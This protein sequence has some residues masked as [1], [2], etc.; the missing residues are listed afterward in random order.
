MARILRK[1]F[2]HQP[3]EGDVERRDRISIAVLALVVFSTMTFS[4]YMVT[5]DRPSGWDFF[6]K[7]SIT[8]YARE[9]SVCQCDDVI[10]L[11]YL[12]YPIQYGDDQMRIAY[13]KSRD[14]GRTWSPAEILS[15]D[16]MR[17]SNWRQGVRIACQGNEVHLVWAEYDWITFGHGFW[18][19]SWILHR[20]SLDGGRSWEDLQILNDELPFDYYGFDVSLSE[21]LVL[22]AWI[23]DYAHGA[24][25]EVSYVV[26]QDHGYNWSEERVPFLQWGG[27]RP[28]M[29]V[30]GGTV[31]ALP[32]IIESSSDTVKVTGT[33]MISE[34][35]GESW[36]YVDIK[37]TLGLER[38][39]ID[40]LVRSGSELLL[41]SSEGLIE[42]DD[43]GDTWTLDNTTTVGGP[44]VRQG[45]FLV[46]GLCKH[47]NLM[48]SQDDGTTWQEVA[49]PLPEGYLVCDHAFDGED[50][51][52][53]YSERTREEHWDTTEIHLVRTQDY[54][55]TWSH[56]TMVT[57]HLSMFNM[58]F[59]STAVGGLI[60]TSA[61]LFVWGAREYREEKRA[62]RL[63][64]QQLHVRWF[65][66]TDQESL[67][68][69]EPLN[70]DGLECSRCSSEK[71]YICDDGSGICL[72]CRTVFAE[73]PP[74]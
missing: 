37:Q 70:P 24:P 34:D 62:R 64:G 60:I 44:I 71:L 45:D 66:D 73:P 26:S 51:T 8:G 23:P 10:H 55:E 67:A 36:E 74:N 41:T 57:D 19:A 25:H 12:D 68:L 33:L 59:L 61:L 5:E 52:L 63:R 49:P 42:S 56:S 65:A 3:Y 4:V 22:V 39:Y 7:L 43:G 15:S 14:G 46:A 30:Q 50:L 31:Y 47:R 53:F 11:A 2:L 35:V 58:A 9:H 17:S 27:E 6:M 32:H 13:K 72:D 1:F 28:Y 38:L 54:G 29:L 48:I 18:R 16:P 21:E 20:A 40:G 69:E